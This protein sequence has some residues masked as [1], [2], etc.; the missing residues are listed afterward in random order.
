MKAVLLIFLTILGLA[1]SCKGIELMH[2]GT[3]VD[4]DGI[5]IQFLGFEMADSLSEQNIPKAAAAFLAAGVLLVLYGIISALC[6][7]RPSER[8]K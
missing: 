6:L 3:D 2:L 5:G 7:K 8:K 4:G 1:L